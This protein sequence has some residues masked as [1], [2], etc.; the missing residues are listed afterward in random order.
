MAKTAKEVSEEEVKE[1]TERFVKEIDSK[2][3][4]F[5]KKGTARLENLLKERTG[6][7]YLLA[8]VFLDDNSLY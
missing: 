5:E 1:L 7:V 6:S 3:Y 2:I 8:D 4:F